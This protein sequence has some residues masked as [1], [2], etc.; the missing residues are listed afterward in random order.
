MSPGE[1]IDLANRKAAMQQEVEAIERKMQEAARQSKGS[2]TSR[3][4]REA[5]SDLQQSELGMRLQRAARY[6]RQGY[7]AHIAQR[8]GAVTESINRLR[9]QLREA[10]RLAQAGGGGEDQGL[11]R[12][13]SRLEDMRRLLEEAVGR[14]RQGEREDGQ[15][16]SGQRGQQRGQGGQQP[17][18]NPGQQGRQGQQT[19]QGQGQQPGQGSKA[20]GNNRVKAKGRVS[21]KPSKEGDK[22][23]ASNPVGSYPPAVP[24]M[25][26]GAA[27]GAPVANSAVSKTGA[28]PVISDVTASRA[29][30]A[31][32]IPKPAGRWSAPCATRPACCRT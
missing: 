6:V 2:E 10:E 17:G 25:G 7:A 1:E 28:A 24:E 13:L 3:K 32:S 20:A 19:G 14:G 8:E 11:E 5:L 22:G 4:L 26:S 15:G 21:N 27:F 29:Q 30:S 12:T 23:L 16:G 9:D 18:Q 31:A